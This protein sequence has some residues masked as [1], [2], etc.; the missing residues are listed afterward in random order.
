[1]GDCLRMVFFLDLASFLQQHP[2]G[3][4]G[5]GN[6]LFMLLEKHQRVIL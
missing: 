6:P 3:G 5:K 1:M 2:S 4:D